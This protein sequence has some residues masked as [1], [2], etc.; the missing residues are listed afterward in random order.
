MKSSIGLISLV[1]LV[2]TPALQAKDTVQV[3]PESSRCLNTSIQIPAPAELE[4][5][6]LELILQNHAANL[7]DREKSALTAAIGRLENKKEKSEGIPC[8]DLGVSIAPLEE[9]ARRLVQPEIQGGLRVTEADGRGLLSFWGVGPHD[10]IVAANGKAL[11]NA[12]ALQDAL[13]GAVENQ[14]PVLL[15][16]IAN[17]NRR[18]INLSPL[19]K[20]QL[21][22]A[23]GM[24][25]WQFRGC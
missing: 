9:S 19:R 2:I 11:H 3:S 5:V 21:K 6:A 15:D 12:K 17:G 22:K 14:K 7:S 4:S 20:E 16:V 18:T 1:A 10:L 24:R 25:F 23:Q 8:K 13:D